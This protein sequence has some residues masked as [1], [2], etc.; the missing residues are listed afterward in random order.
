MGLDSEN[1]FLLFDYMLISVNDFD[2]K[3]V[4]YIDQKL[5]IFQ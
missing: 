1:T 2:I 4:A 3:S 5:K